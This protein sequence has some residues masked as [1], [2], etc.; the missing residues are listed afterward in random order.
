MTDWRAVAHEH[1]P[2]WDSDDQAR[3]TSDTAHL[4]ALGVRHSP[5]PDWDRGPYQPLPA[6]GA[7]FPALALAVT[8]PVRLTPARD[9][10]AV[11]TFAGGRECHHHTDILTLLHPRDPAA[12]ER[13]AALYHGTAIEFPEPHQTAEYRRNL[14]DLLGADCHPDGWWSEA[15]YVIDVADLPALTHENVELPEGENIH[16]LLLSANSDEI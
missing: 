16:L 3:A 12:L 5:A 15:R 14:H 11:L 2:S 4:D 13:L 8:R 6:Y 9:W 7:E 1:Q 10:L